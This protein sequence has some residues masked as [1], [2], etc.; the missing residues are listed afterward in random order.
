VWS[1]EI[2]MAAR[3]FCLM[4]SDGYAKSATRGKNFTNSA[5]LRNAVQ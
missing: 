1:E 2:S 5:K 4:K 3:V